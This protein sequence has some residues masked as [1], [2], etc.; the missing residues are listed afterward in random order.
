MTFCQM[1]NWILQALLLKGSRQVR[2][3][4]SQ[5][6]QVCHELNKT[7]TS[8]GMFVKLLIRFYLRN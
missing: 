5:A 4:K 8:G 3:T 6:D 1:M 2:A 7:G